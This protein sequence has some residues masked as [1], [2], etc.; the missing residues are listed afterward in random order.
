[1]SKKQ[2]RCFSAVWRSTLPLKTKRWHLRKLKSGSTALP[3]RATEEKSCTLIP[4]FPTFTELPSRAQ[5]FIQYSPLATSSINGYRHPLS[6]KLSPSS[7][8]ARCGT[9]TH[10]WESVEMSCKCFP[11][12]QQGNKNATSLSSVGNTSRL[13][14]LTKTAEIPTRCPGLY[15][16][17]E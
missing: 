17:S 13:P 1:M 14:D 15:S 6:T 16:P 11:R 9:H 10:S 12:D 3:H 4:L 5:Q 2:K 8:S 7:S